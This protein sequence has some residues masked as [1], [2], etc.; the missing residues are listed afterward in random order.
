MPAGIIQ[1][2]SYLEGGSDLHQCDA[3]VKLA[4]LLTYLLTA[5]LLPIGAWTVYG[6]MGGLLLTAML[7]LGLPPDRLLRRS[8]VLE[9]PILLALLPQLFLTKGDFI[10]FGITE[11]ISFSFS[12]SAFQK[13]ASIL[14]RSFLSLSFAVVI[15]SVTRFEDLLA[16]MRS[17]GLPRMLVEILGLMWRYLSVLL[18]EAESMLQARASRSAGRSEGGSW[19]WRARVTGGM[20]GALLL[21]TM[22][23]SERIYQSM[24]A[25]GYDGELRLQAAH[26]QLTFGQKISLLLMPAAG[27]MLVWVAYGM[28]LR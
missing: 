23:R 10:S 27:L 16:A 25:R 4:L 21:R 17:F 9:I 24:Q 14:V 20:A 5:A 8:L 3:R 6:L 28:N 18:E 12:L 15:T 19:L 26:A 2:A 1:R 13:V 22:E 7:A 11:N